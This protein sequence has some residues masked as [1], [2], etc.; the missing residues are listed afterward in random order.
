M[1]ADVIA[2]MEFMC[3]PSPLTPILQKIRSSLLGL[4][5]DYT[6]LMTCSTGLISPF[7]KK[8]SD[9]RLMYLVDTLALNASRSAFYS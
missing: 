3:M 4:F 6:G 1:V 8:A 9:K 2:L 7:L 5:N